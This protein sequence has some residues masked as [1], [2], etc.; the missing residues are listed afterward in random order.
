MVCGNSFAAIKEKITLEYLEKT[1]A[2]GGIYDQRQA[3][4]KAFQAGMKA[5]FYILVPRGVSQTAACD[6][7]L[8]QVTPDNDNSLPSPGDLPI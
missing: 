1:H 2:A 7:N 4:R 6:A 5:G 8:Y 3:R